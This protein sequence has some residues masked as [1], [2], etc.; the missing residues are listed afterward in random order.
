M[1]GDPNAQHVVVYSVAMS[2]A[3]VTRY[4]IPAEPLYRMTVAQYHSAL[5]AGV[6]A[7][8][9][10]IELLEGLLVQKMPKQPPHVVTLARL[11]RA[12]A[13]LLPDGWSPRSQ[14]PIT[15]DDGEPEPDLAVVR[16]TVDDYL[17][18]HPGPE[19][20]ALVVEVSDTT[21]DRDRG[22]KL[23]SYARA[24]L[25]AYWIVNLVDRCVEVYTSP[26]A[27]AS[28]P[29]YRTRTTWGP[30]DMVELA[31]GGASYGRIPVAAVLP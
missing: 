7:E 28:T 25:P 18:H 27:A 13:P 15:L 23:R 6:F 12:L 14:D 26:D 10:P 2:A 20:I 4:V 9:E 31:F 22:I 29:T 11:L 19:D 5:R 30:D 3:V 16:G 24:G 8:G 21:L 1:H 17:D